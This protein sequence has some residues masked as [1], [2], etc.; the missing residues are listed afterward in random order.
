MFSSITFWYYYDG[1]WPTWSASSYHFCFQ[2]FVNFVLNPFVVF[3]HNW[4]GFCETGSES[5]VSIV[6][7]VSGVVPMVVSSWVNWDLYFFNSS[8]SFVSIYFLQLWC[9]GL[10]VSG[11]TF[12]AIFLSVVILWAASDPESSG[13]CCMSSISRSRCPKYS[14]L[15][16]VMCLLV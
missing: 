14:P 5:L 3:H 8:S 16:K 6:I 13:I 11:S 7:L 4:I 9:G 10:K 15:L 12:I 1:C 2:E